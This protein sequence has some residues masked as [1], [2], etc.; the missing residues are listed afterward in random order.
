[1]LNIIV[2]AFDLGKS[3]GNARSGKSPKK[4]GKGIEKV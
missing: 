4:S 2:P 1:V 3:Y